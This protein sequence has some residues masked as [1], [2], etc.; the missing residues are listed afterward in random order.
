MASPDPGVSLPESEIL[1]HLL[2]TSPSREALVRTLKGHIDEAKRRIEIIRTGHR[3]TLEKLVADLD[4]WVVKLELTAFVAAVEGGAAT[5]AEDPATIRRQAIGE[6]IGDYLHLVG[7]GALP[8]MLKRM[9]KAAEAA[10]SECDEA[11]KDLG[12]ALS[13]LAAIR[14][15]SSIASVLSQKFVDKLP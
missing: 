7:F 10:A 13:R 6:M 12:E 14:A 1:A 5:I 2:K 9:S 8:D 3:T 15:P 11:S 4:L